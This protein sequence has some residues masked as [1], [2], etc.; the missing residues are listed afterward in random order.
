MISV[1]RRTGS[2]SACLT[3]TLLAGCMALN[4]PDQSATLWE[5]DTGVS[6]LDPVPAEA[7][8]GGNL[9]VSRVRAE[10]RLDTTSMVYREADFEPRYYARNRWVENPTKQLQMIL[11]DALESAGVADNV[12]AAPTSLASRYR[13]D[14]ELLA[15]EHDY[16]TVPPEAVLRIRLRLLRQEGPEVIA[17]RVLLLRE[18]MPESSAGA[19]VVATNRALRQA[20][21]E[22]R[23]LILDAAR[24]TND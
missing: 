2:L 20:M 21:D 22:V 18:P 9:L 12:L 14:T 5:L 10:S 8:L 24:V 23:A 6:T 16:R 19:G 4:T 17:S 13:L 11:V 3:A 7:R 15:L 1:I